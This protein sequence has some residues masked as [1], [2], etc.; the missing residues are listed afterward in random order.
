MPTLA[1]YLRELMEFCAT[2][3]V[4]VLLILITTCLVTLVVLVIWNIHILFIVAFFIIFGLL[5]G[6]YMATI[7]NKVCQ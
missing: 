5:E 1:P 2:G 6:I 3:V 7:L 4:M